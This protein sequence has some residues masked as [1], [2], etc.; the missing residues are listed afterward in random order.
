MNKKRL[1]GSLIIGDII[2][3]YPPTLPEP[4]VQKISEYLHG[5]QKPWQKRIHYKHDKHQKR[6]CHVI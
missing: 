1:F 4:R 5:I 2:F 6:H 3:G